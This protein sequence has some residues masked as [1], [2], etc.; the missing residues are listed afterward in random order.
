MHDINFIFYIIEVGTYPKREHIQFS[1]SSVIFLMQN[2][3]STIY[4]N[5]VYIVGNY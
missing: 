5:I 4:L 2:E 1:G 3:N